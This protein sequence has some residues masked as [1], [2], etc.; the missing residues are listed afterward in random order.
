MNSSVCNDPDP[1]ASWCLQYYAL[2][3]NFYRILMD[4]NVQKGYPV[5]T[6]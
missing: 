6:M 2:V 5:P 1:G 4:K 3:M